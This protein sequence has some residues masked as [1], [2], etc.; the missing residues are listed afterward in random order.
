MRR[1]DLSG[2]VFESEF[3]TE[4]ELGSGPHM[5]QA[6]L[7]HHA[8]LPCLTL[9]STYCS[10]YLFLKGVLVDQTTAGMETSSCPEC[11]VHTTAAASIAWSRAPKE[12]AKT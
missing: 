9:H 12:E 10:P 5:A 1:M 3:M 7:R 11:G 2:M 8:R 6:V 4:R